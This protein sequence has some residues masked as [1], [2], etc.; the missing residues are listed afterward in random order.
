MRRFFQSNETLDGRA[1]QVGAAVNMYY[2]GLSH[3]RIVENIAEMFDRPEPS[4]RTIYTWVK[5]YTDNAIAAMR[6]Y[7]AHTPDEWVPKTATW[8]GWID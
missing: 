3:K 6:E 4:K 7:S 5:R 8:K 1:K 2:D